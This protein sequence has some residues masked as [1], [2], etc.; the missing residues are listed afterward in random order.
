MK[1][2]FLIIIIPLSIVI[3]SF[4]TIGKKH[5]YQVYDVW[6]N[7]ELSKNDVMTDV[8]ST[9]ILVSNRQFNPSD[10]AFF[11]K[12]VDSKGELHIVMDQK[13]NDKWYIHYFDN[14]S[15]AIDLLPKRNLNR[16]WKKFCI[17]MRFGFMGQ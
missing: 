3:L 12:E 1:Y 7:I 11:T 5:R 15:D 4:V 8:D 2:R 13:I 16:L 9:F 14:L 10:S 6:N 17:R